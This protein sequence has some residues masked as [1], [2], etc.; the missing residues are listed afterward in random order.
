MQSLAR[1][2]ID[3][4]VRFGKACVRGPRLTVGEV[5]EFLASGRTEQELLAD[6]PQALVPRLAANEPGSKHVRREL[7]TG[8]RTSPSGNMRA[9]MA[10]SCSRATRTSSV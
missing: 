6:A 3:P 1:I 9:A 5:L 10:W 4:S 7:G 2:S 8:P